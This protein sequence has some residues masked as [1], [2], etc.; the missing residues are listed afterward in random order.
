ML[1]AVASFFVVSAVEWIL[2]PSDPVYTERNPAQ[3]FCTILSSSGTLSQ[4]F[5]TIH[6]VFMANFSGSGWPGPSISSV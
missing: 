6:G 5:S 3:S 4:C 1:M 2:T